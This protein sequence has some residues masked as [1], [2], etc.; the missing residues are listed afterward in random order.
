MWSKKLTLELD[1]PG[2]ANF[3]NWG[4]LGKWHSCSESV[5]IIIL[6]KGATVINFI[7]G[8][9]QIMKAMTVKA[10]NAK[11]HDAILGFNWQ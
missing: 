5:Y 8:H 3:A 2:S 9:S 11:I 4:P 10:M 6:E 1:K 7:Q